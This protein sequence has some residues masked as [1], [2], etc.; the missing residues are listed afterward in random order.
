[1]NFADLEHTFESNLRQIHACAEAGTPEKTES[2][3]QGS[4]QPGLML[5]LLGSFL[6]AAN[7]A[8]KKPRPSLAAQPVILALLKSVVEKLDE[9][10]RR[11]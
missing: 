8:P 9:A 7:T 10:L 4:P 1:M 5:V 2:F 6:E 3:L 11:K